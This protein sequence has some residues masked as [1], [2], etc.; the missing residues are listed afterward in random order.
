MYVCSC[1]AVPETD[2]HECIRAGARSVEE[3][4]DRCSAGTGCGSC[5]DRLAVLLASAQVA[6]LPDTA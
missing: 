1:A 4:G 2:V 5:H 6:E 3:L